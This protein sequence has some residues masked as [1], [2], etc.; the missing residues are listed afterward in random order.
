VLLGDPRSDLSHDL[1]D[2]ELVATGGLD[3]LL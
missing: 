3:L 2:I 1:L